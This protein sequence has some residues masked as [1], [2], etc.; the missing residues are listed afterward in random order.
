MEALLDDLDVDPEEVFDRPEDPFGDVN[1]SLD[2]YGLTV[3][4]S[5]VPAAN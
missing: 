4:G 1:Q 3:C 5:G 2:E